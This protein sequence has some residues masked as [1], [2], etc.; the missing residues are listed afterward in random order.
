MQEGTGPAGPEEVFCNLST[1]PGKIMKPL[2]KERTVF[3]AGGFRTAMPYTFQLP[4]KCL[5]LEPQL[6]FSFLHWGDWAYLGG[7]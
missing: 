2:S 6:G 4:M 1:P 3:E 7:V 5:W